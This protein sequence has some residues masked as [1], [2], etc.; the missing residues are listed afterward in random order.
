MVILSTMKRF[1][2]CQT[3][4]WKSLGRCFAVLCSQ[5]GEV[6]ASEVFSL[7]YFAITFCALGTGM[8]PLSERPLPSDVAVPKAVIFRQ[9]MEQREKVRDY[10]RPILRLVRA[11]L[12]PEAR[13]RQLVGLQYHVEANTA[14]L[15]EPLHSSDRA[16]T[17]FLPLLCFVCS[18]RN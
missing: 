9:Q 17:I 11:A 14:V 6:G 8:L 15:L 1:S 16:P 5:L 12:C 10:T 7:L 13:P 2:R 4:F 18:G 3:R